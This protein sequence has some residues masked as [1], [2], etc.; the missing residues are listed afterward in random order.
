MDWLSAVFA[1]SCSNEFRLSGLHDPVD[2][3]LAGEV[4]L[5]VF[6]EAADQDAGLVELAAGGWAD[7]R[8]RRK[9]RRKGLQRPAE[10]PAEL[11]SKC[12]LIASNG[13]TLCGLRYLLF[14]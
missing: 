14:E 7:R 10:S 13:L 12:F 1:T 2:E 4:A 11:G 8:K 6:E 3:R 9:Q 5:E